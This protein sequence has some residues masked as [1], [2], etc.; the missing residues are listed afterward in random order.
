MTRRASRRTS[1]RSSRG[2]STFRNALVSRLLARM[3]NRLSGWMWHNLRSCGAGARSLIARLRQ[4]PQDAAPAL[5]KFEALEPRILLSANLDGSSMSPTDI[6]RDVNPAATTR[7]LASNE[8]G[9]G[10][11]VT[12]RGTP[13]RAA[14]PEF[15]NPLSFVDSEVHRYGAASLASQLPSWTIGATAAGPVPSLTLTDADGTRIVLTMA[16]KGTAIITEGAAGYTIAVSGSDA[17]TQLSAT[18]SGGDGRMALAAL[19][20]AGEMKS[21]SA[22]TADLTGAITVSGALR[23]LVLGDATNAQIVTGGSGLLDISARNFSGVRVN[24]SQVANTV[25]L[26]SW[27]ASATKGAMFQA[28]GLNSLTVERQF[29]SDLILSGAGAGLLVLGNVKVGG[30]VGAGVWSIAGRAG[31]IAFGSSDAL[32]RANVKGALSQ[33]VVAGD[34]G[35]LLAAASLQMLQVVGSARNFTVLVGADLGSDGVLGGT[36]SAADTFSAGTLGRVRITGAVSGSTF[37]VGVNPVN[38]SFNDGDDVLLGTAANKI[39]ELYI[40]GALDS[41]SRILAP[42]FPATVSVNGATVNPTTLPQLGTQP[43]DRV[44][45]TV[46]ARLAGDTGASA[47]DR[48]TSNPAIAGSALDAKGATVLR[49]ALDPV[50]ATLPTTDVSFALQGDGSFLLTATQLASLGGG[51]LNDGVHSVRVVALDAAGNR[52]APTDVVFT[53]DRAAP[54]VT[55][56]DLAPDSDSGAAGDQQTTSAIVSLQGVGEA[57]AQVVLTATGAQVQAGADGSFRFD[58]IALTL[59]ANVL[60]VS[61]FD[62]AGNVSQRSVTI[63]RTSTGGGDATLP[64]VS[65]ALAVDTGS[66]ASDRIT[67]NPAIRGSASDNVKVVGLSAILDPIGGAMPN[68]DI[69]ASMQA[70]GTFLLSAAQLAS[71]AGGA[72]N[73]GSHTLRL[74]ATDAAGNQSAPFDLSFTYDSTAPAIASFAFAAADASNDSGSQTGAAFA[75]IKGQAEIGAT[76]TLASQN[77]STVVGAGGTFVLPGVA[78]TPGENVLTLSATDAA[79]NSATLTRTLTRVAQQQPDPVLAWNAIALAAIKLDVSNPT[80]ATRMLAIQSIA[81]YDVLAAIEGTPAFLVKQ[82]VTGPVSAEAAVAQAAY[83]VLYQLYPGQR[84][85]FDAALATSLASVPAGAAKTAGIALGNSIAEAVLAIRASDGYLDYATDDGTDELGKWRPTGPLYMVSQDPQWQDVTPFVLASSDQLRAPP[86]PSLDSAEYAASLEKTRALGAATGSTRTADQTQ[87]AQFWADGGGS[88]TPPGHWN[89]IAAQVAAAQGNSLSANAR[90]MAEL[91]VAL[92]DAAIA[93]WDTKYTYDA[94]RPVTAIQQADLDGNAGTTLDAAWE[95]LLITPPHPEYVSGHSTF[96]AAAAGILNAA[97]GEHVSFSTTS[98]TLPGVT[99]NYTSFDQAAH[100]AGESRI[101]GGIHFEYS[102]LAGQEMGKQVGAAVLAR[103]AL[104]QD[105]QAPSVVLGD[106]RDAA[107]TNLTLTGQVLDNL[108]GVATLQW[109]IDGGALHD[110]VFDADGKFSVTTALALNGSADGEHTVSLLARDTAGNLSAAYNRAFTLDTKAPVLSLASLA[111]GDALSAS[112]RLTG[113]TGASGSA[114]VSLHYTVDGG[115]SKSLTF[116]PATGNFDQALPLGN[117]GFGEHTLQLRTEDGAGN[118]STLSRSVTITALGAFAVSGVTPGDGSADIGTTFRPQVHFTRAVNV[119]TLNAQTFYATGPDGV[120][121]DTT[122][123]PALDGSF[124][125]LFFNTPMPG[126][127]SITLHLNGSAIRAAQDGLFLDADGDGA[128]GGELSWS[129]STVSTTSVAGTRLTGRVVDPGPDL[130][131]MT[132]DDVRRGPD[133]VIHTPDDVFQLP[134]AHARVFIIGRPDLTT[135]TDANGN[136]SFDNLPVGHVKVG[137]DGRTATNPPAGVFFPEMVMDADLRP[138]I[139]NTLMGSMGTLEAQDANA[140]RTEVYLPRVQSSAMQAVSESA[141]TTITVDARSAPNL[142]DQQRS[143]LSLT[144][145]P[146]S[147]IGFD[148]KV[149]QNVK[150]GINTVPPAL[151]KDML[152]AG[153]MQHTFDITIQAP[154]VDTFAQPVQISF[155]NVFNAAAGTKLNILSFDHTTGM[156]VINGTATV[157]AD[158]KSV[159]SDEG[160]GISAPGWHG[161]TPP[162]DCGVGNSPPPP[163]PPPTPADTSNQKDPVTLPLLLGEAGTFSTL[164]WSAPAKLPDTPP[165][166]P[167]DPNCPTPP[168]PGDPAGKKQPFITVTI[169]VSGPLADF[170]KASGSLALSSTTFTLQAGTGETKTFGASAKSYTEL[171]A[172]G[173]KQLEENRLY[174]SKISITEVTGKSDGSTHTEK[175]SYFLYRFVDT[176]DDQHGDGKIAFGQT[177]SDGAGASV[178]SVPL[179]ILAGAA[180]PTMTLA[181]AT[182]FMHDKGAGKV[183]FDPKTA[184]GAQNTTIQIANPDNG[185]VAGSISLSGPAVNKQGWAFNAASFETLVKKIA[186]N[187]AAFPSVSAAERLRIDTKPERDALLA[188]ISAQTAAL[189]AAGGLT[190]GIA[191]GGAGA[192]VL[193]VSFVE[194][195][196]QDELGGATGALTAADVGLAD[197]VSLGT[198]AATYSKAELAFRAAALVN[199]NLSGNIVFFLDNFFENGVTT[200]GT[201]MKYALGMNNAHE[202]GHH[203]GLFHTGNSGT[204]YVAGGASDIMRQGLYTTNSQQFN[205][206]TDAAKLG[207]HMNYTVQEAAKAVAYY[208]AYQNARSANPGWGGNSI[209]DD[210][211]DVG[212]DIAPLATPTLAILTEDNAVLSAVHDLGNVIVD[213]A[214]GQRF[215]ADWTLR[216]I[217]T[218]TLTLQS[219]DAIAGNTEISIDSSAT[220]RTLDA[221]QS[222]TLHIA[223]DPLTVGAFSRTLKFV[224]DSGQTVEVRLTGNGIAAGP[225][226][227]VA[228]TENNLGGAVA[229][230]GTV[231]RASVNVITNQGAQDLVISDISLV[232]GTDA[233]KLTGIVP[234]AP[235]TLKTGESFTFGASFTPGKLGLQQGQIRITSND[236]Q[237]PSVTAGVVA[238][239]VETRLVGQWGNDYVAIQVDQADPLRSVSGKDGRF[240]FFLPS[241]KDYHLAVFDPVTGLLA[242]RTGTTGPSGQPTDLT[243][244]LVF[245]ASV[246]ADTDFDGLPDDIEFAI[247]SN[248]AK[249]DTNKD[250]INDFASI[251]QG[252][253]PLGNLAIPTGVLAAVNLAGSAEAVAVAGAA[254]NGSALT[255]YVATG[256][257]GLAVIDASRFTAPVLVAALDLPGTS[258][259]VAVDEGRAVV[260]VA[261]GYAGLHLVD[262][263][264]PSAPVL[265]QSVAFSGAVST[266]QIRDGIAYVATGEVLA[267]VDLNTGAVLATLD[268]GAL[269]G[270]TLTDLAFDG[271]T[272][273]TMDNSRHLRA[274]SVTGDVLTARGALQLANGGGKLFVGGGVAYIGGVGGFQQGFSTVN[275]SNPA[276]LVLLSDPDATNIVNSA[277]VANGSGLAVSV[278]AI[279]GAGNMVHVMD[280]SDPSRTDRFLT[281]YLL[282]GAPRDLALANGLAFVADG[283]GGLQIVNYAAFDTKGVAPTVSITVDTVDVDPATPGIQVLEGR[284]VSVRPTIADDVQVRNIELLVNGQVVA[285]DAS[286]PWELITQAPTIASGGTSMTL[287]VRA[288]D[289]GGNTTLSAPI[290]LAVVPDTFAPVLASISVANGERRFFVRSI[291]LTFD[292]PLDAAKLDLAGATLLR[293]GSDGQFGTA[294]DTVIGLHFDSRNRGQTLS[295][296]ADTFLTPGEYRLSIAP[297]ILADRAGNQYGSAIVRSFTVRPASDIRA[298]SGTAAIPSAPSANPGQQIGLAVPFDPSTAK[299]QVKVVDSNGTVSTVVV[300]VARVN[301]ATGTAYFNLPGDAV[302]GDAV[303]YSQVGAVRTD[304]TDGTFPLQIIPVITSIDVQS[305]SADGS[306]AVVVLHGAGFVEGALSEYRFGAQVITDTG[307]ASGPDVQSVYDYVAGQY[308]N[309]QVSITVPLTNGVFGAINVKTAGGVS[310]S[311]SASLDAVQALAFSG[312]PADAATASANPGQAITLRGTG[313]STDSDILLR[314]TDYNGAAA[315]VRVSPVAASADGTQATLLVPFEANGVFS[316]QMFGSASQPLLQIVPTLTRFSAAGD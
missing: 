151:V 107:S 221:G 260:A 224:T 303:V 195:P 316:L 248:P 86:P 26:G 276:S 27:T 110:V 266:V 153:V 309:G 99:R 160:S 111:A 29:T 209:G 283:S 82:S 201:D 228:A 287:Q 170:M 193:N 203:L 225:A 72:L 148:G 166:P 284:T 293:A 306:S 199:N 89:Q 3:L 46:S 45:P 39:Q 234:G 150:I 254:G 137:I 278:G 229:N 52:S 200:A 12:I 140:E 285:N 21:F 274:I 81:V 119:A 104:S 139:N 33:L 155:P 196:V 133:G 126:G 71:L 269:G 69:S 189:F 272:L 168:V 299:L 134:I 216:N 61:L 263:R 2:S 79:G 42:G 28:G 157:S 197:L 94:W 143:A 11:G 96:S 243:R 138:G 271:N 41:A 239:G 114:I 289:T 105:T 162:G 113:S 163:P 194:N 297:S 47:S 268:L 90:L 116:D 115:A 128:N 20:V 80:V 5:F 38:G 245:A 206:T 144:V 44:A 65:A 302:S 305:V 259:D 267:S 100:E 73:A 9:D 253:N 261:A 312:T 277:I 264:D 147:A 256:S 183:S 53:L 117:L 241:S 108:S 246:A 223:F 202:I 250:G 262:V 93:C 279:N 57:L 149:M 70:D 30:S 124:A 249:G 87:Q 185:G 258:V 18:T 236:A 43:G 304:F 103:F 8:L 1:R 314:Y 281:Q 232:S 182:N 167:V 282:P 55:A 313:L 208:L 75:Q 17:T 288:T 66:S 141:P 76:I 7:L 159:V 298:A 190:P 10:A 192:N 101:Y 238:T 4:A 175:S 217:G 85:N 60:S 180:A 129:F 88:I 242:N 58:G 227:K 204:T 84:A 240:S 74:R 127:S 307:T 13:Q 97:F 68:Q 171:I 67:S 136:F 77:L 186:D 184:I 32:W 83:R 152:P 233:F 132:F 213:G 64:T 311:F 122:I 37:M 35:G 169:D 172:G 154:G 231:S 178:R 48:L 265:R 95:P 191:E 212:P 220:D 34:V 156:L 301:S 131:P 237:H 273:Y 207:L 161:V 62:A 290:V 215:S 22:A 252:I 296:I 19:D 51:T 14:L 130:Q 315:M 214:A 219:I 125:W 91:N 286:F 230:A 106:T 98:S 205:L 291:D 270:T 235:I 63:T 174:G 50:G 179:T 295:V 176:T 135:F 164:S 280:V 198:N 308:V 255:A 210:G 146:G 292:E 218:G 54:T 25:K 120:K 92:A 121:L 78:L 112:S 173:L 123:V 181:D 23:T 15:S 31:N 49:A 300:P 177:I 16:G 251:Q 109:R 247:G 275:V 222:T 188:S 59:G 40:G 226:I 294:D 310:A 187:A 118:V 36:G 244:N 24:T 165:P 158:G 257:A 211:A 102:N 6:D 56:L 145:A 142:T